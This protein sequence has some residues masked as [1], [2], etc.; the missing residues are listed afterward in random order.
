[1]VCME[2]KNHSPER[3]GAPIRRSI[4]D[5]PR[6]AVSGMVYSGAI[7]GMLVISLAFSVTVAVLSKTL[8]MT[9]DE[10]SD[11]Q[12]YKYFSYVLY[13][14]VYVA[15]ILA[16]ALIYREKPAAFGW[17]KA[18]HPKY[19]LIGLV[20]LF[21]LMFSFNFVSNAF[22]A[23]L[24]LFGYNLPDSSLPSLEGGGFIGVLIVVAV[25]PA[26]LEETLFRGIILEGIKDVGTVAA[27][28]LGGALFCIFH[29][30][31]SQTVY[32]FVCGAAF[33][34][35]ALRADSLLPTVFIH[36]VN[37]AFILFEEKYSFLGGLPFAGEVTLY[38]LSALCL[39]G[40]LAYLIFFDKRNGRKKE[41]EIKPFVLSALA[42][43]LLCVLF[44]F[45][46]FA[47]SLGG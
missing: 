10:I 25:L 30:N 17:R 27:C 32:Q 7:I 3:G 2:Q 46:N 14:V 12:V 13:Q 5:Q 35:L 39:L 20:L 42:G 24:K 21:G 23:F 33:T 4:F 26:V 8:G 22:I 15:V 28:L 47:G 34:L 45:V 40:S 41:G 9:V 16:F 11:T 37:N 18:A 6:K 36:F 43:I 29:Q 44:W 31:P 38:V 19:Y 1:M